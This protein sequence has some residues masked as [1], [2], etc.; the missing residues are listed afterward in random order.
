MVHHTAGGAAALPH[1]RPGLGKTAG[2]RLAAGVW[3]GALY[4]GLG[5]TVSSATV[6]IY[7]YIDFILLRLRRY[8]DMFICVD[9]QRS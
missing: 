6:D 4:Y 1:S 8:L 9:V 3:C 5:T 7:I 2:D